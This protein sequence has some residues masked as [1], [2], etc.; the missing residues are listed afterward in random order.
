[1]TDAPGQGSDAAPVADPPWDA[2]AAVAAVRQRV[3]TYLLRET[4][5]TLDQ[6]GRIIISRGST[7]LFIN[8]YPQEHRRLV[9]VTLTAPV[10]YYV[11]MTPALFEKIGRAHV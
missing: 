3:Q 2:D 8:F 7:R 4:E 6:Q 10:A 1:M 5:V 9:F 11:P